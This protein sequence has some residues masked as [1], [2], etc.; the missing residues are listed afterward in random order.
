MTEQKRFTEMDKALA[1]ENIKLRTRLAKAQD[2]ARQ[3]L[4]SINGLHSS[5]S[6]LRQNEIN[7]QTF[8]EEAPEEI[9]FFKE[10]AMR[11]LQSLH[12]EIE[13]SSITTPISEDMESEIL[14]LGELAFTKEASVLRALGHNLS[15]QG[16]VLAIL[17][18]SKDLEMD[19]TATDDDDDAC[20]CSLCEDHRKVYAAAER[21]RERIDNGAIVEL[22]VAPGDDVLSPAQWIADNWVGVS[23]TGTATTVSLAS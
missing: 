18:A 4:S 16:Q 9:A 8:L 2:E 21:I 1:E 12:T 13:V 23:L 7:T 6:L 20:E 10:C 17:A 19:S 15:E 14:L 22:P 3:L 5:A 11:L